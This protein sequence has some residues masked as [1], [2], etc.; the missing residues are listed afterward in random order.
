VY[1]K[2]SLMAKK[3]TSPDDG[4]PGE[5]EQAHPA[6]SLRESQSPIGEYASD[7]GTWLSGGG[8]D[9]ERLEAARLAREAVE[10]G[11]PRE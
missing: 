2:E 1:P 11:K 9:P 6:P 5:R 8:D 7:D 4:R 3:R 10:P